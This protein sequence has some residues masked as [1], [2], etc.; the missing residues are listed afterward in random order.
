MCTGRPPP[1]LLS[2]HTLNIVIYRNGQCLSNEHT[3][4]IGLYCI[5][6]TM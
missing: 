1:P 5:K 3:F 2:K 4:G 6:K